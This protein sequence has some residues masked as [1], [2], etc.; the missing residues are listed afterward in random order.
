MH[1]KLLIFL[2]LLLNTIIL[3]QNKQKSPSYPL[4]PSAKFYFN[5]KGWTNYLSLFEYEEEVHHIVTDTYYCDTVAALSTQDLLLSLDQRVIFSNYKNGNLVKDVL[6]SNGNLILR[7]RHISGRDDLEDIDL[8]SHITM[9]Y[10]KTDWHNKQMIGTAFLCP[11]QKYNHIPGNTHLVYK[12][13]ITAH[14]KEY[15]KAY[16]YRDQ[17]FDHEK[18]LPSTYDLNKYEECSELVKILDPNSAS[19]WMKKK[20]R[21]SHNAQGVELL[22][23]NSTL[24]LLSDLKYGTRCGEVHTEYLIQKYIEN[25]LLINNKKFDFRVYMA[26][27]SMDPLLILYHDGF[28]R[29]T[30][31]SYNESSLDASVHLTNTALAM[32]YLKA[33]EM[34]EQERETAMEEQMWTY[35]Q[36]QEYL[37]GI[38]RVEGDWVNE[39]LR[40][41]M[42]RKMLHLVRMVYRELLP[43]PGVFELFGVDFLLDEDLNLW[44]LE[45]TKS[46]AMKATS[47]AKG[48]IQRKMVKDL[49]EIEYGMLGNG[50]VRGIVERSGFQYVY[51]GKERGK[52]RYYGLIEDECIL[53]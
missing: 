10:H 30:L 40:P 11:G 38:G 9:F 2:I 21:N 27:A 42:K 51:D 41:N 28:L 52:D 25:P 39:Y 19:K 32:E 3:S 7:D 18:F 8:D 22:H 37:V 24:L 5:T 45:V 49:I 44:F 34:T 29:I 47:E 13:L 20:S 50:D 14:I 15:A 1:E 31:N 53:D 16:G 36:L 6:A 26:I 43:H 46:P 4:T 48:R 12:D 17:C 35:E 23:K 33:Q